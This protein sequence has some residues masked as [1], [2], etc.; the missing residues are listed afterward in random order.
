ML[1]TQNKINGHYRWSVN[2]VSYNLPHTPY[3]I[4][5]KHKLLHVFDQTAPPNG[6]DFVNYDIFSKQE[7]VNAT[8]SNSIYRLEFNS[9]VDFILQNANTMTANNS[10]THPWHLHGHDF[11]VMGYGKVGPALRF[12]GP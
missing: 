7:N 6:Y 9:T 5:L 1:N 2:N 11:W 3:L 10:D 4:A 12:S 8:Y